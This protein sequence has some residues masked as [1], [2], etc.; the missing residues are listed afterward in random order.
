MKILHTADLHLTE[1]AAER[2]DAFKAIINL[3]L[4]NQ[5]KLLVICGDL[6]DNYREAEKLRPTLRGYFKDLPF[7]TVILP[8]N[9][10]YQAYR[11]GLY[12][13]EGVTVMSEGSPSLPIENVV[14]WALPHASLKGQPLVSRLHQMKQVM[15]PQAQ[16]I[17]LYHGELLD[18]FF[19]RGEM[20]EEGDQRYMPVKLSYFEQLPLAYILAGHFHSRYA[21]WPLPAGGQFIYC[22]SPV[23][24]TRRECGRRA[25]NL[26]DIEKGPSEI[27]LDTYHYEELAVDLNPF[28]LRD[29]RAAV[30][31]K[32]ENMHPQARVIL[33][34]RGMFDGRAL[35]MTESD[36][37]ADLRN[38]LGERLAAEPLAEYIDVGR[39]LEDDLFQKL[40]S[41][42]DKHES[43]DELKDKALEIAF[44]AFRMVKRCS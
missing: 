41:A 44:Q 40:A 4:A 5:V 1:K 14:L 27:M 17:L 8:G 30:Q 12:F 43:S 20:G 22:G 32:L 13:G 16:N 39:V 2:W 38:L 19:S 7:H 9:H 35:K 3:A 18:A 42:I 26:V 34:I 24:I 33:Q 29:P 23:A 11:E 36:L 21:V 6:F 10:D 28:S 37:A 25:V 31:E 15:N